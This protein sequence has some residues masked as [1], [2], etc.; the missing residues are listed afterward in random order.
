MIASGAMRRTIFVL[1]QRILVLSAFSALMLIDASTLAMAQA[2]GE[3]GNSLGFDMAPETSQRV[4]EDAVKQIPTPMAPGPVKPT[5]ESLEGELQV[6]DWFRGREVRHLHA[7]WDLLCA[8][9]WQRVVREVPVCGRRRQCLEG[10]RR[11]RYGA[12][13]SIAVPTARAPGT[14]N[15]LVR[16]TNSATRTSFRCSRRSISMPMRGQRCSRRRARDT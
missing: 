12:W 4:V 1:S 11:Q 10:A 13:G 9:A 15:T 16:P 8:G 3:G 7:L 14:R 6:P 2:A 5:W